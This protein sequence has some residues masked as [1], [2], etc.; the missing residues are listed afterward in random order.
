M[1]RRLGQRPIR[2]SLAVSSRQREDHTL[3]SSVRANPRIEAARTLQ[4]LIGNRNVARL[5]GS[6]ADGGLVQRFGTDDGIRLAPDSL[7]R[8]KF[9]DPEILTLGDV[10]RELYDS[11]SLGADVQEFLM[12]LRKHS[13]EFSDFQALEMAIT[14]DIDEAFEGDHLEFVA[15]VMPP[16]QDDEGFLDVKQRRYDSQ[17]QPISRDTRRFEMGVLER[18]CRSST[19]RSISTC[20]SEHAGRIS[21]VKLNGS[22][23]RA[24]LVVAWSPTAAK[25]PP[26]RILSRRIRGGNN[27][28]A[29]RA[30]ILGR[31]SASRPTAAEAQRNDG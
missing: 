28:G 19:V 13:D 15:K 20:V 9:S 25:V 31:T 1:A 21:A 12:A 11:G 7:V 30:G 29:F 3:V 23:P 4:R 27:A 16:I 10:M 17:G 2:R 18:R 24:M 26:R 5:L 6:R 14:T 8:Q 22:P